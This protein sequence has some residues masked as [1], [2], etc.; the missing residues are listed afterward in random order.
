MGIPLY[1]ICCFSLTAFNI[2]SLNLIFVSLV[3]ICPSVFLIGFILYETLCTSWT[4][5]T[6]S[7][8]TLER[9]LTICK[10]F[11]W[12]F[13][14]LFFWDVSNLNVGAFNVAA[15]VSETV[16]IS[17][18]SFLFIL[19]GSYP[20]LSIFQLIYSFFCLSYATI[21]YLLQSIF[22]FSNCAVHYCWFILCF[23]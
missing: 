9:F 14:F 8:P 5:L 17:F 2:F 20:H 22:N 10:Y 18:H 23:S 7:F 6:I 3:N 11:L 13:L 15:E 16:L 12:P 1:V 4:W 21:D 19:F